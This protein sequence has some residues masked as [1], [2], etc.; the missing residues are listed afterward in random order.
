M[1]RLIVFA[2]ALAFACFIL[3]IS[4][5]PV[6]QSL[7]SDGKVK[8]TDALDDRGHIP[9]AVDKSNAAQE[10]RVVILAGPHKTATTAVQTCMVEWTIKESLLDR[11]I[12]PMP[13]PDD[14]KAANLAVLMD[15]KRFAPLLAVLRHVK[16]FQLNGGATKEGSIEVYRNRMVQVWEEGHDIVYGA[17]AMDFIVDESKNGTEILEGVLAILPDEPQNLNVQAVVSYRTLRVEHLESVWHEQGPAGQN[18]STFLLK[19]AGSHFMFQS[20][21][22]GLALKFLQRGIST[23][24][25][26]ISGVDD[27]GVG[28]CEVVACDV[29][30]VT[31]SKDYEIQSLKG[32][33]KTFDK[34]NNH[35]KGKGTMDLTLGTLNKI[36]SILNE[37]DCGLKETILQLTPRILFSH[38]LFKSC[39]A[40]PKQRSFQW[41][42]QSIQDAVNFDKQ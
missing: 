16:L 3:Y 18:F 31:C 12:W 29:L 22:L 40:N 13:S 6:E 32:K 41:A 19:P 38:D 14:L 34:H 2:L 26:D 30:N 10:Q 17:E 27:R 21:S 35:K 8:K 11:W 1:E 36:D 5:P 4:Q 24:I 28:M 33:E 37:Y 42:K 20:N 7:G 23:T 25:I 15:Q 9:V 39:S